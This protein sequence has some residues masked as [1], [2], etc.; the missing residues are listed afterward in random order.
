MFAI[1]SIISLY[2][3]MVVVKDKMKATL[4]QVMPFVYSCLLLVLYGLSFF[5]IL[6]F[7]DYILIIVLV[8]DVIVIVKNKNWKAI[9]ESIVS[10]VLDSRSWI[11]IISTGVGMYLLRHKAFYY[12]DDFSFWAIDAKAIYF[13]DGLGP[14]GLLCAEACETYPSF[15]QIAEWIVPHWIGH[16]GAGLIYAGLYF[17]TQIYIA[18]LMDVIPKN[19]V[20]GF[21]LGI[22]FCIGF[23]AFSMNKMA[24]LSPDFFVATVFGCL[25]CIPFFPL[26]KEY[27]ILIASAELS[28]LSLIKN[29]SFQWVG[30][31]LLFFVL[32]YCKKIIDKKAG[33]ALVASSIP[34][35]IWHIYLKWAERSIPQGYVDSVS[36]GLAVGD[37]YSIHR[38]PVFKSF[39]KAAFLG[40]N[41]SDGVLV[42]LSVSWIAASLLLG[43]ALFYYFTKFD[44][45]KKRRIVFFIAFS[46]IAEILLLLYFVE[47]LFISQYNQYEYPE[48]MVLIFARYGCPLVIGMAMLDLYLWGNYYIRR[49]NSGVLYLMISISIIMTPWIGIGE[50]FHNF[51]ENEPGYSNDIPEKYWLSNELYDG[52]S[53]LNEDLRIIQSHEELRN[54][55]VVIGA[56]ENYL[57]Y[58]PYA[59]TPMAV[60]TVNFELSDETVDN[61]KRYMLDNNYAYFYYL[62]YNNIQANDN[63]NIIDS[64]VIYKLDFESYELIKID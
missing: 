49:K 36:A 38:M 5:S 22:P 56:K 52:I 13:R 7:I 39:I 43:G 18:P 44:E 46:F 37:D 50:N 10:D 40:M 32:Y 3:T 6:S 42:F 9:R 15:P 59:L 33:V 4:F 14:K 12:M 29:V 30:I 17:A 26:K 48:I 47:V 41:Q 16:F 24:T 54:D 45:A 63:G 2:L 20:T 53:V 8:F 1:T 35:V 19:K 55:V 62:D 64:R 58:L 60:R 11:W 31:A 21:I 57:F 34:F 25:L 61:I 27:R 51:N 28:V 23:G